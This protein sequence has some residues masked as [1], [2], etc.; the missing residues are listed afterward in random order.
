MKP[1]GLKV[2]LKSL[3][4][5]RTVPKEMLGKQSPW[6]WSMNY[7]W[8]S[9]QI[10]HPPSRHD[11]R[12]IGNLLPSCL[13][14]IL[15]IWAA[16]RCEGVIPSVGRF[17]WK[18]HILEFL[19]R[20]STIFP[21]KP[22]VHILMRFRIL[23]K[24]ADRGCTI[25]TFRVWQL[26]PVITTVTT[27]IVSLYLCCGVCFLS[28]AKYCPICEVD[29]IQLL[30][31][32]CG[33]IIGRYDLYHV[34]SRHVAPHD[35]R[36]SQWSLIGACFTMPSASCKKKKNFCHL[37]IHPKA[38]QRRSFLGSKPTS[39]SSVIWQYAK[40]TGKLP[41]GKEKLQGWKSWLH[42]DRFK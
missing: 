31:I 13:R 35:W 16:D 32:L 38:I 34:S 24:N 19:W 30:M 8:I 9:K 20:F 27:R 36:R 28:T 3:T 11:T 1:R 29:D 6:L 33:E 40:H 42:L 25:I 15:N 10:S 26:F 22:L 4:L 5:L 37:Y 21:S 17:R 14:K 12:E 39:S 2:H 7:K 23:K 41:E 18:L